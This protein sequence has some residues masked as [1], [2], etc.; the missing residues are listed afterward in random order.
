MQITKIEASKRVKQFT[1]KTIISQ[2]PNSVKSRK[3]EKMGN[4]INHITI[5]NKADTVATF[6]EIDLVYIGKGNNDRLIRQY[7]MN[8]YLSFPTIG[9]T[10]SS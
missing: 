7:F 8:K 10:P 1:I 3:T 5:M 2:P 9:Q 4:K 6:D